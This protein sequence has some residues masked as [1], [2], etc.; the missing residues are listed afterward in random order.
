MQ[1]DPNKI[2]AEKMRLQSVLT[3]LTKRGK[4][5]DEAIIAIKNDNEENAVS[6]QIV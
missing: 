5:L 2:I 3:Q 1:C 4:E 6:K